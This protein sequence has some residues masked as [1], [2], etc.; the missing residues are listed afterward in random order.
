[1]TSIA[2]RRDVAAKR[3]GEIHF[4]GMRGGEHDRRTEQHP[5]LSFAENADEVR[6]GP[7]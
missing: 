5:D 1:M 6:A 2:G 4:G 3:I 7:I